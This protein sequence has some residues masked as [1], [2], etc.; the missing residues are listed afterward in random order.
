MSCQH[1]WGTSVGFAGI[2]VSWCR[3]CGAFKLKDELTDFEGIRGAR[4]LAPTGSTVFDF[5]S[6]AHQTV[7]HF[8]WHD[9]ACRFCDGDQHDLDCRAQEFKRRLLSMGN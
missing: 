4:Q 5:I 7:E 1:D 6:G 8:E 9:G 3:H 2:F